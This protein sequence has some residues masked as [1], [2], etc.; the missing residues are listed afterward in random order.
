MPQR[1]LIQ[2]LDWILQAINKDEYDEEI[3]RTYDWKSNELVEILEKL[4]R[5]GYTKR[6][7]IAGSYHFSNTPTVEGRLYIGYEK[8]RILEN[9]ELAKI[10]NAE[11][12]VEEYETK[13]YR[14]TLLAGIVAALLLLWQVLSW[15]YPHYS[16]YPYHYWIWETIPKE[17]FNT[18][19]CLTGL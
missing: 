17:R 6:E 11:K 2:K 15:F 1:T 8:Y 10:L 3:I 4:S 13:L 5:D 19:H 14:A 7:R 16:D 12:R 18:S 9:E